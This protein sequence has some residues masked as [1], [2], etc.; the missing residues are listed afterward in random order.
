[1][2]DCNTV[3]KGN[4]TYSWTSRVTGSNAPLVRS[5]IAWQGRRYLISGAQESRQVCLN[6]EPQQCSAGLKG[7]HF[8][9]HNL[10]NVSTF[11]RFHENFARLGIFPL[12]S[13]S[14]TRKLQ[15]LVNRHFLITLKVYHWVTAGRNREDLA[16]SIDRGLQSV[17]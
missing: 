10:S 7:W 1:M 4:R 13:S 17:Y 14:E 16:C 9:C 5:V 12:P 2:T 8:Q 6:L 3:R 11:P 15:R